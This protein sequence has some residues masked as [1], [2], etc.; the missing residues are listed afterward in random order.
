MKGGGDCA[1][2]DG[3]PGPGM[4]PELGPDL[5]DTRF[6][7]MQGR[8]LREKVGLSDAEAAKVEAVFAGDREAHQK[9]RDQM[10]EAHKT[11]R[12]LL[13]ED[14]N[15]MAAYSKAI[16]A[17]EDTKAQMEGLMEAHKVEISKILTPKQQAKLMLAMKRLMMKA[18]GKGCPGGDGPG[19]CHGGKGPGGPGPGHWDPMEQGRGRERNR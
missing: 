2:L 16:A 7:K 18:H 19:G 12:Q 9:L 5:D 6:Q 3:E 14:S 17:L 4:G 11:L 8:L 15:D 13:K 10:R 1:C